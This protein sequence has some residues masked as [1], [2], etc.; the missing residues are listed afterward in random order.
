[1]REMST[2]TC[3][4]SGRTQG[5]TFALLP[6]QAPARRCFRRWRSHIHYTESPGALGLSG[7]LRRPGENRDLII[8]LGEDAVQRETRIGVEL[9]QL[10]VAGPAVE[11]QQATGLSHDLALCLLDEQFAEATAALVGGDHQLAQ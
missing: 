4:W 8:R 9:A 10:D 6:V 3:E 2:P 5:L 7:L 11:Q 1:M